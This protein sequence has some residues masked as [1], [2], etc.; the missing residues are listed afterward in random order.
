MV[1]V[2]VEERLVA[3]EVDIGAG[4]TS[5]FYKDYKILN[6]GKKFPDTCTIRHIHRGDK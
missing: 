3:M 2:N 6:R 4:L 1:N 5:I